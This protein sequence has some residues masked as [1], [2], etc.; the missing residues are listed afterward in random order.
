M[1]IRDRLVPPRGPPAY[2]VR[3]IA[4]RLDATAGMLLAVWGVIRERGVV[5]RYGAG[6]NVMAGPSLDDVS[7]KAQLRSVENRSV[8][9]FDNLEPHSFAGFVNMQACSLLHE[10][11]AVLPV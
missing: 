3:L 6:V 10:C 4:P 7:L 1:C 9:H 5:G 11:L 2:Q 8:L